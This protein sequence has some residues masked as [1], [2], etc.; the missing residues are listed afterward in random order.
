[1]IN[2]LLIVDDEA[3][4]AETLCLIL[5]SKTLE[6]SFFTNPLDALEAVK[7]DTFDCI[8]SDL[9]MP[10]MNGVELLKEIR[11]MGLDTPFIIYT[12]FGSDENSKEAAKYGC[13]EVIEKPASSGL[14]E[15]VERAVNLKKEKKG[16][17]V[18][19]HEASSYKLSNVE[20]KD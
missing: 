6:P 7:V 4:L 17:T 19:T 15:C 9:S 3:E 16:A 11:N 8:V 18:G 5:K 14:K 10:V 2:R 13:F 1:V 20:D 12:A